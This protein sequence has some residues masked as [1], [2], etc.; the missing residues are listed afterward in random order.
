MQQLGVTS[1]IAET[2]WDLAQ[3]YRTKN[4]P[5]L[6]QQHYDIAHQLFTQLGARKDLEKIEQAWNN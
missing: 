6:A 5:E 3:L 4:N 2:T 1:S